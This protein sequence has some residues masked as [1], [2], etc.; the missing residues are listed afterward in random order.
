[1]LIN[2]FSCISYYNKGDTLEKGQI[3]SGVYFNIYKP[4]LLKDNFAFSA[5]GD[6]KLGVLSN[7]N[8]GVS[9][10]YGYINPYLLYSLNYNKHKVCLGSGFSYINGVSVDDNDPEPIK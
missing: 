8:L 10:S 1:M 6:I 3:E 9:Y 4:D 2:V 7:T 5:I